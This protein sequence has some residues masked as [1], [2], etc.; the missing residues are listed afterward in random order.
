ME[1]Q[2]SVK[3]DDDIEAM[4]MTLCE[5]FGT[6]SKAEATRK[7]IAAAVAAGDSRTQ[8]VAMNK[9]TEEFFLL[10]KIQQQQREIV[11]LLEP[12]C[13]TGGAKKLHERVVNIWTCVAELLSKEQIAH[14]SSN[15]VE[16]LS[17]YRKT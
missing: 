2:I 17:R 15:A 11:A 4:L 6:T 8:N 1:Y 12:L 9:H 10:E 14:A 7:A 3:Y 13:S 5:R 16:L